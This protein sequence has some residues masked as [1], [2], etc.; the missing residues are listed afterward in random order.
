MPSEGRPQA[1]FFKEVH[2]NSLRSEPTYCVD[3]RRT[4]AA[5]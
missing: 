2:E 5:N 1:K 3:P 4:V